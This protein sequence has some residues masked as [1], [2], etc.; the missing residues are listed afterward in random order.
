MED[1]LGNEVAG[2]S[3]K[4]HPDSASRTEFA[5]SANFV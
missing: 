2:L 5:F 4:P 3:R 1:S